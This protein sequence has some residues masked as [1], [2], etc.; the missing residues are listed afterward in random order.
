M[1]TADS[2]IDLKAP[3][4]HDGHAPHVHGN[5]AGHPHVPRRPRRP[6]PIIYGQDGTQW[7]DLYHLVL[8]VPW[9]LFFLGLFG[10]FVLL[11]AIFACFY[12]ADPRGLLNARPGSYWDAF[13]FSVQTIGSL[14]SP[15]LP[16]SDYARAVMAFE[17][18][19]GIVN[20]ALVTGVV[21]A[22][23][24]RPFARIVIS[25][26][27]TVVP[28]EGVPT[29]MI[30]AANQRK[31]LILDAAATLSLARQMTT[32][33]GIVMR[34]FE[35]LKL[36]RGRTPLFGLS[37]TIMHQIDETSPLYGATVDS[38]LDQQAEL[39]LFLSGTDET[40][41][42]MIY[43]RH[44]Y[45]PDNILFDRRFVDVLRRADD[46]ERIEIDLRRFHD[47]IEWKLPL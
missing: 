39:I 26:V 37:W 27:A 1:V 14:N 15:M 8:T 22:R 17:A 47:T 10:F 19:C 29:L 33:E 3:H 28:F 13:F 32:R 5:H 24:S 20:V 44:D 30:R 21:F 9:P 12:I 34:R 46:G 2:K 42:Q 11:N 41:S 4:A 7:K 43:A 36:V 6:R 25:D 16:Q 35:E 31:N 23:F 40:L 38:L 45:A 18:F